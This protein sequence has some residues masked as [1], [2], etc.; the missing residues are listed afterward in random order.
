MSTSARSLLAAIWLCGACDVGT[1]APDAAIELA[2][3]RFV[4]VEHGTIRP[5]VLG[6]QAARC[7]NLK[8]EVA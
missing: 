1:V 2:E 4:S 5:T 3:L 8:I 7:H 6:K